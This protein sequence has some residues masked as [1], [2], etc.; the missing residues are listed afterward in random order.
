MTLIEQTIY[1]DTGLK[2]HQYHK[3]DGF[4]S[5]T[6]VDHWYNTDNGHMIYVN[7]D[8]DNITTQIYEEE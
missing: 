6:G 2:P 5:G 1:R 8:Q 4:S 7:Q 3:V